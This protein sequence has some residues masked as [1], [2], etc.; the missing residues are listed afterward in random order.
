[1][2]THNIVVGI[3]SRSAWKLP[4]TCSRKTTFILHIYRIYNKVS[5]KK[6]LLVRKLKMPI[7]IFCTEKMSPPKEK[8]KKTEM[9]GRGFALKTCKLVFGMFS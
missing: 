7:F 2:G 3:I 5:Q 8:N 9:R 4:E 6:V 1:M